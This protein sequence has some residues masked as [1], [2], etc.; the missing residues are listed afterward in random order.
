MKNKMQDLRNHLFAQLESLSD[1]ESKVDLERVKAMTEISKVLVDSAKVEVQFIN[2]AGGKH[3]TGF[4][5]SKPELPA[6]G[7]GIG[8]EH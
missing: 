6:P 1:P 7:K 3:S 4:I 5:E 8:R 2:A